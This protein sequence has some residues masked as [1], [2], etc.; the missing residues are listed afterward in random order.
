M[1][2]NSESYSPEW[3]KEYDNVTKLARYLVGT[4]E[5]LEPSEVVAFF[6]KPWKWSGEWDE[7]ISSETKET[8]QCDKCKLTLKTHEIFTGISLRCP[9]CNEPI[10][11]KGH[12]AI[13]T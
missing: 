11:G 9:E 2:V 1:Q 5:L 8:I 10:G 3:F 7:M 13:H 6:E 4:C 12:D